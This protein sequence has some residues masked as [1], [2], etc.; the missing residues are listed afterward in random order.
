[1]LTRD[2]VLWRCPVTYAVKVDGVW[3]VCCTTC[4][5][6][7]V[8]EPLDVASEAAMDRWLDEHRAWHHTAPIPSDR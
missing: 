8:W 3:R 2:E 4:E 1:M 7:G 6:R 5:V